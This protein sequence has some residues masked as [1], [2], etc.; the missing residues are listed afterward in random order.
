MKTS[1]LRSL[2]DGV[3]IDEH[4]VRI[5]GM[6][7]TAT[8]TVL[9]LGDGTLLVHSPIPATAERLAA[10]AARGPVAHLFAP[11]TF[12]HAWLAEWSAAHPSAKVHAPRGLG[13]ARPALRIDRF[14]DEAPD[15]SLAGDIT[16]V[17]IEGFRLEEAALI[18]RPSAT[19][20]VADLVHHVGRP[21]DAWTRVYTTAMGFY[22]R[23]AMSRMIRWTA[24]S[25]RRAARRGVDAILAHPL[26]QLVVGHGTPVVGEVNAQLAGALAFLPPAG[27]ARLTSPS[28][29][30]VPRPCG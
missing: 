28:S 10:V 18:H 7:L 16:A 11:N 5:V 4:P 13:R 14:H 21:E 20:V 22:D 9:R 26:E 29:A 1:R 23:V 2:T 19:L 12:H 30:L 24:F 25:D 3:W 17:R 15:S 27:A 8:M 6:K